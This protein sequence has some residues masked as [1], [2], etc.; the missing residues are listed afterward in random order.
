MSGKN[1]KPLQEANNNKLTSDLSRE[2][3]CDR[4]RRKM[5]VMSEY[6]FF[7]AKN[8]GE[9]TET[10]SVSSNNLLWEGI[11]IYSAD[12]KKKVNQSKNKEEKGRERS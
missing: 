5:S 4:K 8:S 3:D 7:A 11:L 10:T 2:G 6:P 9:E 1:E 12:A